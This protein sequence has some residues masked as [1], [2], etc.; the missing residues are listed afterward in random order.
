MK[1]AKSRKEGLEGYWLVSDYTM[2]QIEKRLEI[3]DK[4]DKS[5]SNTLT[6]ICISN[7]EHHFDR[8][9][10]WLCRLCNNFENE[11]KGPAGTIGGCNLYNDWVTSKLQCNG[12]GYR[13]KKEEEW[14]TYLQ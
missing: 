10:E 13:K 11:D 6:D 9:H 8:D 7:R 2:E 4:V 12:Y 14:N 1:I 5:L 3:L